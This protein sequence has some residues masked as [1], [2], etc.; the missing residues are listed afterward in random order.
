ML[1]SLVTL[2]WFYSM[3]SYPG[4]F[5]QNY[6]Q[7]KQNTSS[8]IAVP[9]ENRPSGEKSDRSKVE[10][11]KKY[12]REDRKKLS[13]QQEQ[14]LS[15]LNRSIAEIPLLDD[16]EAIARL[17]ASA[18][19][20]LWEIERDQAI[21]LFRSAFD[22]ATTVSTEKN[23]KEIIKKDIAAKNSDIRLEVISLALKRDQA[24]GKEFLDK[25]KHDRQNESVERNRNQLSN[26]EY[27]YGANVT[28]AEK[29]IEKA[30]PL[31]DLDIKLS[32]ELA[33]QAFLI[34]IPPSAHRYFIK[35]S[36]LDQRAADRLYLQVLAGLKMRPTTTPA[37]LLL[38]SA[39]PFGE[40]NVKVTDG[41][42]HFYSS[43]ILMHQGFKTDLNVIRQFINVSYYVLRRY[44]VIDVV[45]ESTTPSLNSM[46]YFAAKLIGPQV[47]K[48]VPADSAKWGDIIGKLA[49]YLFPNAHRA[50]DRTVENMESARREIA[51][52][53]D[54]SSV[55]FLLDRAKN[56]TTTT[57]QDRDYLSAAIVADYRGDSKRALEIADKISDLTDRGNAKSYIYYNWAHRSITDP[58]RINAAT[59]MLGEVKPFEERAYL[60]HRIVKASSKDPSFQQS[61]SVWQK[62]VGSLES[63][64]K[65]SD[66]TK[67]Y[68]LMADS[69]LPYESEKSFYALES[70]FKTFD[71]D[72]DYDPSS[73]EMHRI[74]VHRKKINRKHV[75][76]VP[77]YDLRKTLF[78]LS[79]IDFNRS[80][81]ILDQ[82]KL[83][84][85]RLIFSV[86][87]AQMWLSKQ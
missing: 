57:S 19:D 12:V 77:A 73:I 16:N 81:L 24:L 34:N 56:G 80:L 59:E 70:A 43:M 62:I 35:L 41:T 74:L 69:Y 8:K 17:Q 61:D 14:C 45:E 51:D 48:Y 53:D 84:K 40:E 3:A 72:N 7:E 38:L 44:P 30:I 10:G 78:G 60:G 39:Y 76:K 46:A 52:A 37:H 23:T 21:T 20:A 65:I 36:A 2:V 68:A 47:D 29:L 64:G 58:H 32:I 66:K 75:V 87:L 83:S 54:E 1:T 85:Y 6:F 82:I 18:A 26:G 86:A 28:V 67:T 33:K 55:E 9:K 79:Q 5:L 4:F 11:E 27:L 50:I 15:L 49:G 31:L 42:R 71:G 63:N 22:I 25:Y 13:Y